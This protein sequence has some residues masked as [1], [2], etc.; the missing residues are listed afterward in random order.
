M[1]ETKAEYRSGH[2]GPRVITPEVALAELRRI[3]GKNGN[4]TPEAVVEDAT[5]ESATLHPCF[6]WDNQKAG[7][8]YRLGQARHLIRAVRL[9]PATPEQSSAGGNGADHNSSYPKVVELVVNPRPV[10]A[11]VHV[12]GEDGGSPGYYVEGAVLA[13]RPNEYA[14]ALAEA[15]RHLTTAENRLDELA[16]LAPTEKLPAIASAIDSLEVLQQEL[17]ALA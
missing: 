16:D 2:W 17:V 13:T 14:R 3:N 10:P 6:E 11:F 1:P 15:R 8:E 5:P 7:H 4:L 12:P 9:T